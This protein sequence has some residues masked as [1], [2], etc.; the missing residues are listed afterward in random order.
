MAVAQASL[1]DTISTGDI[2]ILGGGIGNHGLS[3]KDLAAIFG[4]QAK[5]EVIQAAQEREERRQKTKIVIVSASIVVSLIVI[6]AL[7]F[8]T[9]NPKKT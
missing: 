3:G 2:D 4:A 1:F 8:F 5:A 6:F 9:S 7:Y